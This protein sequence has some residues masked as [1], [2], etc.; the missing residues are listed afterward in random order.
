MTTKTPRGLR[1]FNP[2]NIRVS[3]SNKWQ[4]RALPHERTPEQASEREFEVFIAPEWGIRAMAVLFTNYYDFHN[5]KTVRGL[6]SRWAPNNEN[7]TAA[8]IAAVCQRLEVMPD[9]HINLHNYDVMRAL[10]VATIHHENGQQPYSDALIDR[11]LA[12]AGF[13][14]PSEPARKSV[15]VQGSTVAGVA[16]AG[17]L[18]MNL[19][20]GAKDV[21]DALTPLAG[22]IEWVPTVL[23]VV[24]VV[25]A[26][27]A[28]WARVRENPRVV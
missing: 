16:S 6:I 24:A 2:G 1:N 28:V 22:M 18:A 11:G 8:Y 10:V 15:A 5:L 7:N 23:A 14:A 9:T 27:L 13:T 3:S 21:Q 26:L 25:G 12:M 20:Q 17:V 4:G 19:A